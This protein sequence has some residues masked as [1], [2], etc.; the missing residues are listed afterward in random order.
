MGE[1]EGRRDRSNLA[2]K[3]EE[4]VGGA[5]LDAA[6]GPRGRRRSPNGHSAAAIAGPVGFTAGIWGGKLNIKV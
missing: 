5:S 4:M 3:G 6:W 2:L 1:E